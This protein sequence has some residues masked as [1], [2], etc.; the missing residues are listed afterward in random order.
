MI[1]IMIGYLTLSVVFSLNVRADGPSFKEELM[2]YVK[3]D[4]L[5]KDPKMVKVAGHRCKFFKEILILN[6]KIT[7]SDQVVN[8]HYEKMWDSNQPGVK[9]EFHYYLKIKKAQS[10]KTEVWF[11]LI[12]QYKNGMWTYQDIRKM[13]FQFPYLV[14]KNK[15]YDW[16]PH[17]KRLQK[18][19]K[20]VLNS[21]LQNKGK[22]AHEIHACRWRKYA[23]W[24]RT[25]P[26]YGYADLGGDIFSVIARVDYRYRNK[27][28]Y[29]EFLLYRFHDDRFLLLN[30]FERV[31]R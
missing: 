21:F 17:S 12:K 9:N 3:G 2:D 1:K 14:S 10:Q 30:D 7:K 20:E 28:E 27:Y 11:S 6:T 31:L 15:Y 13:K 19:I 8:C 23:V 4:Y 26:G 5:I 25:Y 29:Q 22:R 18:A 16:C 24:G